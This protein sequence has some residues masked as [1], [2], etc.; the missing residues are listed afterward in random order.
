MKTKSI[1]FFLCA[2]LFSNNILLYSASAP[3]KATTQTNNGAQKP[4]MPDFD[5][6]EED[7][8]MFNEFID[9]LDEETINA[10][11]AI[12]EEIIKEADELGID[13]LDYIEMQAQMQE[14]Y[15][16]P[17]S[18]LPTQPAKTTEV[19][20]KAIIPIDINT[21]EMIKNLI[22]LIGDIRQKTAP[23]T[24]YA[25]QLIP[26]KYRLD[27]LVYYLNLLTN[28]KLTKFL[29]EKEFEPL[30]LTLKE[31]HTRLAELE[32]QLNIPEF[33]LE[34][35]NFYE[36]LD[37]PRSATQD[38][39][40]Q[41]YQQKIAAINPQNLEA[42]LIRQG[43]DTAEIAEA[44][45]EAKVKFAVLNEAYTEL[46][47]QEKSNYIFDQILAALSKA[48]DEQLILEEIK[49]LFK[50]HEPEALKT[51]QEREKIEAEARKLQEDALKRRPLPG[52]MI[53]SMPPPQP[54]YSSYDPGFAGGGDFLG[55]SNYGGVT[56]TLT[57]PASAG[58]KA[59]GGGGDK[60]TGAKKDGDKKKKKKKKKEDTKKTVEKG[61]DG[62]KPE[63]PSKVNAQVAIIKDKIKEFSKKIEGKKDLLGWKFKEFMITPFLSPYDD[64]KTL[65]KLA[66]LRDFIK[67]DLMGILVTIPG[68]IKEGLKEFK[69]DKE[70]LALYK[71]AIEKEFENFEKQKPKKPDQLTSYQMIEPL[72]KFDEKK[73]LQP[74]LGDKSKPVDPAKVFVLTGAV[75]AGAAIDINTPTGFGAQKLS[76]L[77]PEELTD[78]EIPDPATAGQTITVQQP[79]RKNYLKK[80]KDAYEEAKDKVDEEKKKKP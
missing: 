1:I 71:K 60:K 24:D 38:D 68:K 62:K 16:K 75:P 46:R 6:S 56:P 51:Q 21:V 50:K 41:A 15:E 23:D 67:L 13:P 17:T 25:N 39:I 34:G 2:L 48:T 26:F 33:S 63:L 70:N 55:G 30:S 22:I 28:E 69:D 78:V 35:K 32:P 45:D 53:F 9:S 76:P 43:K 65:K 36:V 27:D 14:D 42:R 12:G 61:K 7:M 8:K 29:A 79:L 5:L 18:L 19:E 72:L 77:N 11:T 37:L 31:L 44:V 57:P 20:K 80:L 74:K 52:R 4:G 64:E 59:R 54:S 3:S 40:T 10:L 73:I 58:I 47:N 49:K 66:E